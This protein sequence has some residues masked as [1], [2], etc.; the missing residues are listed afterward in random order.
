MLTSRSNSLDHNA[1]IIFAQR[2]RK[3]GQM[4][5]NLHQFNSPIVVGGFMKEREREIYISFL[6]TFFLLT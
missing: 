1:K 4:L 5:L 3:Y 2:L 6:F